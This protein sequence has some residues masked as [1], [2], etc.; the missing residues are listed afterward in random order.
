[1]NK[2]N[3][4]LA[5][6]L[7]LALVIGMMSAFGA[8]AVTDTAND[9]SPQATISP[10]D[11]DVWFWFEVAVD[12]YN[13]SLAL[14]LYMDAD[15]DINSH[16][17]E[18]IKSAVL[19]I[20][21]PDSY[22]YLKVKNVKA[23]MSG[24][25][26]SAKYGWESPVFVEIHSGDDGIDP[27]K[28]LEVEY[29]V[30]ASAEGMDLTFTFNPTLIIGMDADETSLVAYFNTL[31]INYTEDAHTTPTIEPTVE[32]TTEPPATDTPTTEPPAT[33]DPF[34]KGDVN[35]NSMLDAGDATLVLRHVVGNIVLTDRQIFI[36][37]MNEND[38]LDAGD[39]TIILRLIVGLPV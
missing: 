15:Y 29:Y 12:Y 2:L 28:L 33:E 5:F 35:L 14:S 38:D 17:F 3:R 22:G 6:V 7:T 30:D 19:Q 39:A 31:S 8:S 4:M 32:P 1:M 25:S 26:F 36:G 21:T 20:D 18:Q 34:L 13:S 37:D 11:A 9:V 10:E 27:G 23:M 24:G 16:H